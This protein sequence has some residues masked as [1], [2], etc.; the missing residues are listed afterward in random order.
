[1]AHT[2]EIERR[3]SARIVIPANSRISRVR[4]RPG[5]TAHVLNVSRVG[6]LIE[7]DWRLLPGARVEVQIGE[8]APGMVFTGRITRC[9]VAL[10]ERSRV[11]YRAALIFDTQLPMWELTTPSECR[12]QD[13]SQLPNGL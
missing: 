7:T 2:L 12:N 4:L 1:M 10:L 11:Q 13:G 5:R 9:H 6:A 3:T 8:A